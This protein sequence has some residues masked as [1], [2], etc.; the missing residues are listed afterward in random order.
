MN[1]KQKLKVDKP[2]AVALKHFYRNEQAGT[3]I[4]GQS[5]Y[6]LCKNSLR[7]KDIK[8]GDWKKSGKKINKLKSTNERKQYVA[9]LKFT[10]EGTKVK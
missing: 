10:E 5:K 4:V 2:S 8:H 7:N 9:F 6:K 3:L 1:L